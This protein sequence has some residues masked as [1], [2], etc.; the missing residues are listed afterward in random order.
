MNFKHK[1]IELYAFITDIIRLKFMQYDLFLKIKHF[2][3]RDFS[4]SFLLYF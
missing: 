1:D 2:D 3:F 4:R